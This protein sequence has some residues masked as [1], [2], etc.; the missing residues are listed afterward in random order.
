MQK[1]NFVNYPSE[2][3]HFSYGN[4]YWA[5]HQPEKQAIYGSADELYLALEN[6]LNKNSCQ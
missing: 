2:W 3:W 5:Y 1:H 4:R 6:N